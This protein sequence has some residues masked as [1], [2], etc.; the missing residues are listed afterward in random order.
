M[1]GDRCERVDVGARVDAAGGVHLLGRH[2][3]RRTDDQGEPARERE[4]LGHAEVGHDKPGLAG[5]AGLEQQVLRL[6]VAVH[7]AHPVQHV[8]ALRRL[9]DDVGHLLR[10]QRST[11][12]EVPDGALVGVRHDE[13]GPLVVL[14]DV[15][16]AYDVVGV[17]PAQHARLLEKPVADVGSLRPVL[18]QSLDGDERVERLVAVEPDRGEPAR[19]EPR[20]TLQAAESFGKG[21]HAIVQHPESRPDAVDRRSA[22]GAEGLPPAQR[23]GGD[24]SAQ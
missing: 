11:L 12:D 6:D 19:S 1:I 15:I 18:R 8:E 13:V 3:L 16:D 7:D 23:A 22:R 21:H 14:P 5:G 4:R 9:P 20:D 10:G 2:V 24:R 17:G